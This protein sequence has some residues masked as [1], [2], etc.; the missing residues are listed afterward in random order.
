MKK[1]ILILLLS[2]VGMKAQM[3][4]NGK[5]FI[6]SALTDAS[7]TSYHNAG[8]VVVSRKKFTNT[9]SGVN[10]GDC[11]RVSGTTNITIKNCYFTKVVTNAISVLNH[12]GT[13]N[14]DRNLFNATRSAVEVSS[15]TGNTRITNNE[16]INP[17]GAMQCAGQ[18]VQFEDCTTAD[19]YIMYNRGINT[20]GRGNTEDWISLFNTTG[21]TNPVRVQYNAFD[22][23]GP[24]ES[25]GG[26]MTGD[27]G[28]SNQVV[29]YNKLK[30]PGNYSFA[31][32]G[33]SNIQLLNNMAY[34]ENFA[35]INISMYAY[36]VEAPSC[37]DITVTGNY[38][39]I[40]N[41]N[42]WYAPGGAESCGTIAG[43][44]FVPANATG[45][46]LSQLGMPNP[47]I[48]MVSEDRFWRIVEDADD[49]RDATGGCLNAAQLAI[50]TANAGAD[51]SITSS[52]TTLSGSASG[53]S[54]YTY[55][56]VQEKG[57]VTATMSASTSAS[58]TISGL[59]N[60]VYLFRLQARDADGAED[61]D[62][63]QITVN[64]L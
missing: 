25:G 33:G 6:Y 24:S 10:S 60:G 46:T 37:S 27:N 29:S 26:I 1:L 51:Q 50:P 2:P 22:G 13:A 62:W 17:W 19:S 47:I 14:I 49:Y 63:V 58:N 15:S 55:R 35:W 44:D 7:P 18:A 16:F 52:S 40:S 11:L 36:N 61:A 5:K 20:R 12:S 41:G 9:N 54:G 42:Y 57:P 34:Q 39:Y 45:L 56:W 32:A 43:T 23:G 48:K 4:C 53:S 8:T 38:T 59:A 64:A 30:N 3:M 21:T 31:A 28:G